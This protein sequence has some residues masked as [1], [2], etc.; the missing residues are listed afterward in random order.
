[1]TR[2]LADLC[3]QDTQT[4]D[5]HGIDMYLSWVGGASVKKSTCERNYLKVKTKMSGRRARVRS[6][7]A[8]NLVLWDPGSGPGPEINFPDHDQ[9]SGDNNACVEAKTDRR[10]YVQAKEIR[11]ENFEDD[12]ARAF[13]YLGIKQ[14]QLEIYFQRQ[15]IWPT[16]TQ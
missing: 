15:H 3:C 6:N 7:E 9:D 14:F 13:C 16:K 2:E 5:M 10:E 12:A 4:G 1:M 11:K 8:L